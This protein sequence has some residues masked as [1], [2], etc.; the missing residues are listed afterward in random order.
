[1]NHGSMLLIFLGLSA[2]V[3]SHAQNPEE[4]HPLAAYMAG[5]GIISGGIGKVTVNSRAGIVAFLEPLYEVKDSGESRIR[6]VRISDSQ[7]LGDIPKTDFFDKEGYPPGLRHIAISEDGKM[8]AAQ[9]ESGKTAIFRMKTKGQETSIKRIHE[10]RSYGMPFWSGNGFLIYSDFKDNKSTMKSFNF[11]ERKSK[12]LA[13]VDGIV[14][15]GQVHNGKAYLFKHMG[16]DKTVSTLSSIPLTQNATETT[17]FQKELFSPYNIRIVDGLIVLNGIRLTQGPDAGWKSYSITLDSKSYQTVQTK[18]SSNLVP[19]D[20]GKVASITSSRHVLRPTLAVANVRKK[21]GKSFSIDIPMNLRLA[22]QAG[23]SSIFASGNG[24]QLRGA[25]F[26]ID[27]KTGKR[28]LIYSRI[29]L[30]SEMTSEVVPTKSNHDDANVA[31]VFKPKTKKPKGIIYYI[32]GGSRETGEPFQ[33][34]FPPLFQLV[35]EGY[36]VVGVG[37]R[38]QMNPTKFMTLELQDILD[39]RSAVEKIHPNLPQFL[40]GFSY[41]TTLS[42]SIVSTYSNVASWSGYIAEVG[43][44]DMRKGH[45]SVNLRRMKFYLPVAKTT[46]GK[47]EEVVRYSSLTKRN[48][49][50]PK[51]FNRTPEIVGIDAAKAAVDEILKQNGN[52]DAVEVILPDCWYQERNIMENLGKIKTPILIR[53]GLQETSGTV[54]QVQAFYKAAK[55]AGIDVSAYFPEDEGHVTYTAKNYDTWMKMVLAFLQRNSKSKTNTTECKIDSKNR[56]SEDSIV[57]L[58]K[59]MNADSRRKIPKSS[60]DIYKSNK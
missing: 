48:P 60:C 11:D 42:N 58:L 21:Q 16:G 4:H 12:T 33:D 25:L 57:S 56:E 34:K 45:E 2:A 19:L 22:E 31:Y 39:A 23:G 50:S 24:P 59:D 10:L 51:I 32:H 8:I 20:N 52:F 17:H 47:A 14:W 54:E 15:S 3:V 37:Y 7:I 36:I 55:K 43:A 1:M 9:S 53:Q 27:P 41:G 30:R 13:T 26:Q 6:I 18:P 38:P 49:D 35:R 29:D 5:G 44:W 28:R 40:W 46:K